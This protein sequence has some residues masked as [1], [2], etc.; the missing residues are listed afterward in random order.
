MAEAWDGARLHAGGVDDRYDELDAL[1]A[2]HRRA[3]AG[4]RTVA[5]ELR[6]DTGERYRAGGVCYWFRWRPVA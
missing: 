2:P 5:G 1:L 6:F 3:P 4:A